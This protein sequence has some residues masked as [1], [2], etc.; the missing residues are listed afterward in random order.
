MG[1]D[2]SYLGLD[3]AEPSGSA[4]TFLVAGT[5]LPATRPVGGPG[6]RVTCHGPRTLALNSAPP[7]VSLSTSVPCIL[8]AV[9]I[10]NNSSF[11]R[12]SSLCAE[13]LPYRCFLGHQSRAM[14]QENLILQT[15][16]CLMS[17]TRKWVTAECLLGRLRAFP[18]APIKS[19]RVILKQVLR[20]PSPSK[21]RRKGLFH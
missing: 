16:N 21:G 8:P 15:R 7:P 20:P 6:P 17:K 5:W 2:T 18:G 9:I 4:Y 11:Y 19:W 14:R 1:G 12:A 10:I 3:H 13:S